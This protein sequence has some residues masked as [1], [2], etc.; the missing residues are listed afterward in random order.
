MIEPGTLI[1]DAVGSVFMQRVAG[2]WASQWL[3]VMVLVTAFASVYSLMLGYSRIPY[4]GRARWH[5]LPLLRQDPP[6]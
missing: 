1:Y 4:R 5:I 2:F 6:A 3:T